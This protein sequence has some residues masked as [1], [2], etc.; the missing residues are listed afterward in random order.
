MENDQ[1][2]LI[3][4][5]QTLAQTKVTDHYTSQLRAKAKILLMSIAKANDPESAN[6]YLATQGSGIIIGR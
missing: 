1:A 5:L 3:A 4:D 6:R 2:G